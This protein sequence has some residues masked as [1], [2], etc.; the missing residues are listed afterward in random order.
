MVTD[1]D[2][3]NVL[4]DEVIDPQKGK[5]FYRHP[6]PKDVLHI[7]A[8][9]HFMPPEKQRVAEQLSIHHLRQLQSQVGKAVSEPHSMLHGKRFL[10]AEV[11]SPPRFAPLAESVGAL[12]KSYDLQTG[13]DFTKASDWDRVARELRENPPNLLILCPQ[14][15][16]EGG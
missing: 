1:A 5:S 8:S 9:F 13:F 6:I 7:Q 12:G 4:A 10:V 14:C 15:T 16:D 2:T 3:G 11:F